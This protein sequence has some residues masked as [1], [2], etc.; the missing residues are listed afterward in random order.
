[1][2][3]CFQYANARNLYENRIFTKFFKVKKRIDFILRSLRNYENEKLYK[4]SELTKTCHI[5]S[6]TTININETERRNMDILI[7]TDIWEVSI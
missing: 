2:I 5:I 3:G 7:G 4:D 6:P 1:M